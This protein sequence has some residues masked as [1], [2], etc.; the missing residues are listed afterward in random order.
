MTVLANSQSICLSIKDV[1]DPITLR[2]WMNKW[3]CVLADESRCTGAT[4][5]E[6]FTTS[7][8]LREAIPNQ[9]KK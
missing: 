3:D 6:M 2:E 8:L 7:E 4:K 5:E 1:K 9:V